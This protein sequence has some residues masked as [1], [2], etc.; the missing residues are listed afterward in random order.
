MHTLTQEQW[1]AR[2]AAIEKLEE[3]ILSKKMTSAT[4][5]EV[6]FLYNDV[7][8][9]TVDPCNCFRQNQG[10]PKECYLKMKTEGWK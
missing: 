5:N 3:S 9:P 2:F 8:F 7:N 6:L 1:L 10:K 4:I